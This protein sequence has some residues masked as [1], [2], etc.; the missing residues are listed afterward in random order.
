MKKILTI[1]AFCWT[2]CAC[3]QE[4]FSGTIIDS[5]SG[6]ILPYVNVGVIGKNIGTVTNI[7]GTFSLKIS[8]KYNADTLMMSMI[9]YEDLVFVVAD[10]KEKS[11]DDSTFKLTSKTTDLQEIVVESSKLKS[12]IL[13]NK[14]KSKNMIGGFASDKL[15]NE[16]GIIIKIKKSPTYI[17]KF[18]VSI[19]ENKYDSL[20]FRLNF[21]SVKNGMPY[22]SILTENIF[23][24][25]QLKE[26]VLTVDLSEYNIVVEDDFMV[27][28]EWIEDLGKDGLHFSMGFFGSP[29]IY[30][31]T[32]QG[33][34]RKTKPVSI[35]FSVTAKY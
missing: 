24:E 34:W 35:G 7:N 20:K 19:V 16:V 15:G 3:G 27:S 21:Y 30:R 17:D 9:G 11:L 25:S 14:T 6:E 1:M 23:V 31:Y 18:H 5:E 10:F 26:G 13:G 8:T 4:T 28:L 12:K 2:V 32:S 33:D 22:E 29:V